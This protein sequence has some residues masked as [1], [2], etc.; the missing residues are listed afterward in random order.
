MSWASTGLERW[1]GVVE[2][3][4]IGGGVGR[5]WIESGRTKKRALWS[6]FVKTVKILI[7]GTR[8][9]CSSS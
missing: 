9:P 4:G 2:S 8:E 6:S 1:V 7:E 3:V 5:R